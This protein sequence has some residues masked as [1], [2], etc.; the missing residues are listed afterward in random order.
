[1]R[2]VCGSRRYTGGRFGILESQGLRTEPVNDNSE[3][4]QS[5]LEA[6]GSFK[7]RLFPSMC[8]SCMIPWVVCEESKTCGRVRSISPGSV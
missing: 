3:R 1:M 7:S 6:P 4:L 8:T 5:I 2:L